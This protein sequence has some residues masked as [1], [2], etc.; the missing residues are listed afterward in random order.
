MQGLTALLNRTL[1]SGPNSV[2]K[3]VE[4]RTNYKVI[5]C[6]CHLE[7]CLSISGNGKDFFQCRWIPVI[8]KR[9]ITA[10]VY[11]EITTLC[12]DENQNCSNQ[13]LTF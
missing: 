1:P 9:A 6:S 12:L 11:G 8:K 3:Q 4:R 7:N 5:R 10:V 2:K 13:K